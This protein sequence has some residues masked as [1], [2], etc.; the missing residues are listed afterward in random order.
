M[1]SLGNIREDGP[2]V[3]SQQRKVVPKQAEDV[4]WGD[5]DVQLLP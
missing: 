1:I 5:D 3:V 4:E 2:P